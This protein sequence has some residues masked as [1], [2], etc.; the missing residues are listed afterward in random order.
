MTKST[1]G[2]YAVSGSTDLPDNAVRAVSLLDRDIAI[3]RSASGVV[4]AWQNAC[5]HRGMR[6]SFGQVRGEELSC[7]YHGW[8]FAQTGQ[9]TLMPAQPGIKPPAA[10]CVP[11]FACREKH[12]LIWVNPEGRGSIDPDKLLDSSALVDDGL[13]CKSLFVDGQLEDI[14]GMLLSACYPP[15]AQLHDTVGAASLEADSSMDSSN[16]DGRGY[17][18][19]W[20]S[21]EVGRNI[22]EVRYNSRRL[23]TNLIEIQSILNDGES[24]A[25]LIALQM[26]STN[27]CGLHLV[28]SAT[29]D[30]DKDRKKRLHYSHWAHRLRWFLHHPT[31]EFDGYR[32]LV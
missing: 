6:L 16:D 10:V 31:A 8:Q 22:V 32:P 17:S 2:W 21:P 24:D 4:Q 9:C 20:M 28:T 1:S 23:S 3:W 19:R 29:G 27:R 11:T 15:F 30:V 13:F 18:V 14:F 25:L 26:I 12:S 7:R 5:P